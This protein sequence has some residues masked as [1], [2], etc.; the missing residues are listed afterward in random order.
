MPV[1]T[2]NDGY[3]LV[4]SDDATASMTFE[5][6]SEQLGD[7]ESLK[8]QFQHLV[9]STN[10][11][12]ITSLDGGGDDT[13]SNEDIQEVEKI[14]GGGFVDGKVDLAEL[15]QVTTEQEFIDRF[16]DNPLTIAQGDTLSYDDAKTAIEQGKTNLEIDGMEY[17][18][19]IGKDKDG[20][21]IFI[22]GSSGDDV[23]IIPEG[24]SRTF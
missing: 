13:L 2:N 24:E 21:G 6:F 3:K 1:I 20:E 12:K 14:I 4:E 9:I 8:E 23:K 15:A 19:S 18:M 7:F 16:A 17:P 11:T 10:W 22:I 5:D